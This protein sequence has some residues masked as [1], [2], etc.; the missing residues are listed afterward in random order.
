M[1][2]FKN[3]NDQNTYTKKIKESYWIQSSKIYDKKNEIIEEPV[4]IKENPRYSSLIEVV[5]KTHDPD[6]MFNDNKKIYVS[7]K[8]M[9][10]ASEVDEKE[11]QCYNQF[12]YH[13]HFSKKII[14]SG[15]QK[16]GA[17][18]SIIYLCDYYK[19]NIIIY[20]KKKDIFIPLCLKYDKYDIYEYNQY[21][22]ETDI[23]LD[24]TKLMSIEL[25]TNY[26]KYVVN[27]K[28]FHIYNLFL[29]SFNNYKLLDLQKIAG[30]HDI[31]I[32]AGT[33]KKTKRELYD[34]INKN[35]I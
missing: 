14:Q 29:K 27:M 19:Y 8:K 4:E 30:E 10:I 31:D 9:S 34:E 35:N 26:F 28:S 5:L 15:F 1:D 11:D 12:N 2:I 20:D 21:W 6:Y 3:I 16:E 24:K 32:M 7:Q 25:S 23:K 33:K 18:S 13:K 17:L 22:M